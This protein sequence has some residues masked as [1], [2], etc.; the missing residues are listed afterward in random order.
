MR[1]LVVVSL[2]MGLSACGEKKS[3]GVPEAVTPK[4]A[5]YSFI[6]GDPAVVYQGMNSDPSSLITRDNLENYDNFQMVGAHI[7]ERVSDFD[8]D[9][10]LPAFLGTNNLDGRDKD[11]IE[12]Y[13]YSVGHINYRGSDHL[14]YELEGGRSGFVLSNNANEG[15]IAIRSGSEFFEIETIHMSENAEKNYFSFLVEAD[16][17]DGNKKVMAFYFKKLAVQESIRRYVGLVYEY[18][19]EDKMVAWDQETPLKISVCSDEVNA[20]NSLRRGVRD[21]LSPWQ[22][23]LE[24]RLE[25]DIEYLEDYPPFSDVNTHCIYTFDEYETRDR[26]SRRTN[27]AYAL[28]HPDMSTG[29]IISSD[30]FVWKEEFRKTFVLGIY[31]DTGFRDVLMHEIGHFLGL[32]HKFVEGV[33]SVMSYEDD[34]EFSSYD[35]NA[36]QYLYPLN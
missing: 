19:F 15:V 16:F 14:I 26:R 8:K 24:N 29:K 22:R 2:L 17:G 25:V 11:D 27:P 3:S 31:D 7:I 18:L 30:I 21:A 9:T 34:R 28:T 1:V 36:I 4:A 23:A 33:E 10:Y 5:T 32:A 13:I 20:S 12:E 6:H 35:R